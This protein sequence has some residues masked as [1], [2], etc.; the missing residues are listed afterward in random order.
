MKTMMQSVLWVESHGLEQVVEMAVEC[1]VGMVSV[2][3]SQADQRRSQLKAILR[4][5][6]VLKQRLAAD[7]SSEAGQND[8]MTA[9]RGC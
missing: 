9:G 4:A 3:K 8:Q 6:A 2:L 1:S 7:Q 5:R